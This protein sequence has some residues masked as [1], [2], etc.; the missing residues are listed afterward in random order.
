MKR[1]LVLDFDGT[2]TDAEQEAAPFR[3]GYFEDISVLSG[4]SIPEIK[5]LAERFQAEVAANVHAYGWTYEGRIVAPAWVDPY[6]R[7]MPVA[8]KLFD[9]SETLM[10]PRDRTRVLDGILY[11][12][13]YPKTLNRFRPGAREVLESLEGTATYVVTNSHTDPVRGK[14]RDLGDRG[15]GTCSLDWLVARVH[16]S[17]K[18]YQLDDTFTAVPESLTLPGLPR[19]VL[20]RRGKYH[21]KLT[22]LLADEGCD[23]EDLV[24]VGDIF[25]LDLSLPLAM[26]ATVGLLANPYTPDYEQVYLTEHPR[27][28]VLTD[29]SQIP[30][31]G[32]GDSLRF[33][34]SK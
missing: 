24:V 11:K 10:N 34:S 13:N 18:K 15:D 22:E 31:F 30:E 20:L 8:R 28:A 2:M 26:G 19:P 27:G 33:T 3:E 5:V 9:H 17:A 23:W 29:V 32:F 25:E 6:L 21:A 1:L 16:G 7:M 14:L 12:Y 4:L